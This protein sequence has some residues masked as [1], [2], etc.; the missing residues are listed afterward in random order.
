MFPALTP[1][2]TVP[3]GARI[4]TI[5]SCFA[6]NIERHIDRLGY[7]LPVLRFAV[8]ETECNALRPNAILNR[9]T[10]PA[11]LQDVLWTDAVARRGGK[12]R[13]ADC[14]PFLFRAGET[15]WIDLGLAQFRPVSPARF[16]ERRQ[17]IFDIFR[18]MFRAELVVLTLGLIEAWF[19]RETSQ[20]IQEA[21]VQRAFARVPERFV[22][23]TLSYEQCLDSLTRAVAA[24]RARNPQA[25]FLVTTSPVPMGRSFNEGDVLVNNMTSKSVLRAA[26]AALVRAHEGMDYFPSY[27][28]VML[29]KSWDIWESDRIHVSEAFVGKIVA[30]LVSHY[31]PAGSPARMLQQRAFTA[32]KDNDAAAALALV[33]EA[34]ALT[35]E[36]AALRLL[37][38]QC[39]TALGNP[40]AAEAI[41]DALIAA[42]PANAALHYERSLVLEA[43]TKTDAAIE[44]VQAAG[45]LAPREARHFIRQGELLFAAGRFQRALYAYRRAV[46]LSPHR[47]RLLLRVS[48]L[49]LRLGRKEEAL[50]TAAEVAQRN[51]GNAEILAHYAET[52]AHAGRLA[53]ARAIFATAAGRAAERA[54]LAAR[55]SVMLA[56]HGAPEEARHWAEEATRRAPDDARARAWLERLRGGDVSAPPVFAAPEDIAREDIAAE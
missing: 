39:L 4:F 52:L 21:P 6:R 27:E 43:Q 42:D 31:F 36:D 33:E 47:P 34:L 40:A 7:D 11:I 29:T 16:L 26:A 5:G 51:P 18:E 55:F 25:R 1:S 49:E 38:A 56:A 10:P 23:E 48:R 28:S 32:L 14:E 17:Q 41:V 37:Q 50:A 12:V 46:Q 9:Y 22:F 54:D 19:D 30:H 13:L 2:F 8:P 44:A 3:A 45:R 53:E 15:Q 20:Y 35:P 24:I